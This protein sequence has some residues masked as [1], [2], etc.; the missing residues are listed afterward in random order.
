MPIPPRAGADRLAQLFPAVIPPPPAQTFE[1]GLVLGGTVSAGT[2][3]AGALDFL[4]QALEAWNAHP[5]PHQVVIKTAGGASGGAVCTAI[6]GILS[7]RVVP[8]VSGDQS[9]LVENTAT[10]GNPL[11]D[12]WVNSFEITKLLSTSDISADQD[13]DA[14]TGI[15]PGAPPAGDGTPVQHVPSLLNCQMIDDAG[16]GLVEFASAPDATPRPYFAAPFRVVVTLANLRGL[17]FAIKAIPAY[18]QFTGAAYLQRDD[19]AWFAFPNGTAPAAE[20][21]EDEFW[22]SAGVGGGIV[23]YQTLADYATASGSMPV[24][25]VARMLTRPAEHYLYRPFVRPRPDPPGFSVEWIDPDWSELPDAFESGIYHFTAVDGGCFNNDPVGLVHRAL[26]GLVGRNPRGSSQATRAILMIDPLADQP[27]AIGASGRSL[28][29][30]A[31][32]L[33]GLFV[34]GAHY[35]TADMDLFRDEDVFSRFQMVPTRPELGRVGEQ[36][37]A[38]ASLAALAGWCAR[39]FRVHDYLLGRANMQAYLRSELVLAGD[40]P[41]F[42]NWPPGLR[43]DHAVDASGM[44]VAVDVTTPAGSYFLPILPD[45][46]ETLAPLPDWP[47]GALDPSTLH[48]PIVRRL[49]AVL[50]TLRADNLQG[51]LN[52]VVAWAAVPGSSKLAATAVVS[53]LTAELQKA[54]LLGSPSPVNPPNVPAAV[55]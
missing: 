32:G 49:E 53:K 8:H 22:L 2:Y 50:G 54:Q 10:T 3:T 13:T 9:A 1:L 14:G 21:R 5:A 26:G 20:K 29:R 48:D 43:Q 52:E 12:L 11:W 37:L 42:H 55:G 46:T 45:L 35:L 15:T 24:G 4:L 27:T 28:V 38:G 17:P 51:A 18:G 31:G 36:A 40:N 41:L 19:F 6:L 23:G 33:V 47:I 7:S 25:L 34:G 39:E 30:V 16:R 44:R